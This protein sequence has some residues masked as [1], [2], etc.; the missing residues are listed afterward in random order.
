MSVDGL[1]SRYKVFSESSNC[2]DTHL[3]V[4]VEFF[5]VQRSVSFEFCLDGE[6]ME[7]W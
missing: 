3:Y 2:I 1:V 5:K 6:F 7:S 4:V